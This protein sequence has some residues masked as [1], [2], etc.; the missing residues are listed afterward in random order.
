MAIH[1]TAVALDLLPGAEPGY[2]DWVRGCLRTLGP[3]YAR[4]GITR[5]AVVMSGRR[6]IAHY[7]SDRPG[8]VEAAFASPEAGQE[9]AGALGKLVDF[10]S[11]PTTFHGVL[12]WDRAVDYAPKHVALTLK[13]KPGAEPAY[14]EWVRNRLVADFA[15]IWTRADLAR[16]EVLMA[17]PRVIAFYEARDSA[18]VL[19]TF[20]QPESARVM[21]NFLGALLDLDP[22]E[23]AMQPYEEVFVWKAAAPAA[24]ANAA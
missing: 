18:S 8:A 17:G 20:A 9:F 12:H 14:L 11:P 15:G 23:P 24:G 5:K 16:K 22:S 7:E 1:R 6:V 4:T 10:S 19:S 3:V 2:L 13:L 21:Q